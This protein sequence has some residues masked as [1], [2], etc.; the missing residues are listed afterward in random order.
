LMPCLVTGIS[1]GSSSVISAQ[2]GLSITN[3]GHFL[4][5]RLDGLGSTRLGCR[6]VDGR[7]ARKDGVESLLALADRRLHE[8]VASDGLGDHELGVARL[9]HSRH[10]LVDGRP[11][12]SVQ[13]KELDD[14][15]QVKWR[16]RRT[17]PRIGPRVLLEEFGGPRKVLFRVLL[18]ARHKLVIVRRPPDCGPRLEVVG[19]TVHLGGDV[20]E[21][22]RSACRDPLGR[23]TDAAAG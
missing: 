17:Q 22:T 7:P 21:H 3:S 19:T 8:S 16:P 6:L 9:A 10:V 11:A 4:F 13:L 15:L 1:G 23:A 12:I 14:R 20:A 18:V 5:N 2:R